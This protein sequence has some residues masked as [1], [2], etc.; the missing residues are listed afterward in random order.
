MTDTARKRSPRRHFDRQAGV[1]KAQR[2]FHQKGYDGVSVADL[3]QALDINPPS[4]YAAYGSKAGL[5]EHAL[6]RYVDEYSLPLSEIFESSDLA[7]G[8]SALFLA[9]A[10]QYSQ[11][12]LCRGCL[13]TEGTRAADPEARMIAS[14]LSMMM[15][16]M[17]K[18]EIASRTNKDVE[19]LT[20]LVITVIRGLSAAAYTGMEASRL[21]ATAQRA[22]EM[23]KASFR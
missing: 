21:R 6:Q 10:E 17:V 18:Q 2:L 16:D 8:L 1:E 11:D 3:T 19:V 9:A 7:E 12:T 13:V 20:D 4:L 14:G 5:F 22:G 23:C 15:Y